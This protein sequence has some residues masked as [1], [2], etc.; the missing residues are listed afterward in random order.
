MAVLSD[1]DGVFT[2]KE[3]QRTVLRA[4]LSGKDVFAPIINVFGS[5]VAILLVKYLTGYASEQIR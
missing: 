3:E 5:Y 2:S 4:F 1:L